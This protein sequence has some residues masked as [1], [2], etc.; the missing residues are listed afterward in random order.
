MPER[1]GATAASSP[2][3]GV[4]LSVTATGKDVAEAQARAYAAVDLIHWDGRLLPP[5]HRLAGTGTREDERL[6]GLRAKR[7]Q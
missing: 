3:A 2:R 7:G 6:T 4:V 1:S 5:R